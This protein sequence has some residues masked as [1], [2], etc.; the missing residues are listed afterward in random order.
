M[1][2]KTIDQKIAAVIAIVEKQ[3]KVVTETETKSNRKWITT[4]VLNLPTT[5]LNLQTA[6]ESAIVSALTDLLILKDYHSKAAKI[7]NS[8]ETFM[9]DGFSVADWQNDFEVRLGKIRL[10]NEKDKLEQLEARLKGIM[11]EDSK[12]ERELEAIMNE[13]DN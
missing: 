7:L 12:R 3:K 2:E 4:G 11:S 8:K 1:T 6:K 5:K 13:L 10:K 9:A